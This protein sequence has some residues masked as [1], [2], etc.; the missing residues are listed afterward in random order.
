MSHLQIFEIGTRILA[1]TYMSPISGWTIFAG[2]AGEII[3]RDEITRRHKVRF[4]NGR[5]LWATADQVRR[6]PAYALKV[7]THSPDPQPE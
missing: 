4:E 5:E 7:E 3:E 6:D 1:K 2:M